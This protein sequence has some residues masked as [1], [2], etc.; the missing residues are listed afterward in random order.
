MG[1]S[2]NIVVGNVTPVKINYDKSRTTLA[3]RNQSA[4][5][6]YYG[7]DNS[8]S[9]TNGFP[10]TTLTPVVFDYLSGDEPSLELWLI[11]S[12]GAQDVRVSE[13]RNPLARIFLNLA[14]IVQKYLGGA[15]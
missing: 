11:A 2:Y 3:V 5:T 9:A 15:D 6:L 1:N 8:V 4:G 10:V 14:D 7:F 13:G 12:A